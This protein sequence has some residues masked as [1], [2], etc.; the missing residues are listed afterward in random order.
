[1]NRKKCCI[2]IFIEIEKVFLLL[3]FGSE[4]YG[5][6]K[7][8]MGSFSCREFFLVRICFGEF[9]GEVNSIILNIEWKVGFL[10]DDYVK[11]DIIMEIFCDGMIEIGNIGFC[12]VCFDLL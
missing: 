8:V 12:F 4:L 7:F 6:L 2:M 11:C 5:G 1:M 3:D 10:I 9:V